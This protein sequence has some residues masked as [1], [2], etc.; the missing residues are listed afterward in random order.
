MKDG[1]AGAAV[2]GLSARQAARRQ[3]ILDA[4]L[5]LLELRDYER[6]AVRDVTEFASVALATLYHYFPS[7]EH[8]FAEALVQWA[9]SLK[10]SVIT[11]PL[12]GTTPGRRLEEALLRSVRAFERQPQLARL[13]GRLEMSEE[14][15]ARDVL[16]RLD[17][18]TTDVYLDLLTDLPRDQAVRIVRIVDA[19]L[20]SSLRAWSS[21]RSSIRDVRRSLSET[22]A[23]LLPEA[24]QG[25]AGASRRFRA[26][27]A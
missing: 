27:P 11:R 9:S 19:V 20:D 16:A 2:E 3:R 17:A 23:L 22:V 5:S 14:P 6:I 26:L 15:F 8:L 21:G 4:A 18:V 1:T 25:D 12:T 7:K 10:A 24:S 13:I